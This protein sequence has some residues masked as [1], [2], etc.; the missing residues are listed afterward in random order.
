MGTSR[1][2]SRRGF[3]VVGVKGDTLSMRLDFG[4]LTKCRWS[5]LAGFRRDQLD[6]F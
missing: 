1:V 6:E 4:D 5:V 3:R 2:Y